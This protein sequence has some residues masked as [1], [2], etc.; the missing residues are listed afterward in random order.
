M[1][2]LWKT[3]P[4][5]LKRQLIQRLG[6]GVLFLVVGNISWGLSQRFIFALPCFIAMT[7][8]CI[9]GFSV[10]F[11]ALNSGYIVLTGECE[12]LEQTPIMKRTK[13]LYLATDC[14]SVKIPI[15]RNMCKFRIGTQIRCYISCKTCVY[16]YD[17]LKTIGDYIAIEIIQ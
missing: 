16:D 13:A 9:S 4:N 10:M 17:G 11:I 14:G 2:E 6:I 8:F 12:Q 1:K 5:A 3:S 15:R 7:V